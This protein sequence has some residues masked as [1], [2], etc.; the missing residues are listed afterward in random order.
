[1]KGTSVLWRRDG[2]AAGVAMAM[3]AS[4]QD[5]GAWP[6]RARWMTHDLSAPARVRLG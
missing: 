4:Y 2:D 5:R 3:G 6:G 1:M